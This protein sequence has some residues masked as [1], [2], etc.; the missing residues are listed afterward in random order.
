MEVTLTA[1]IP[2]D[3]I[4]VPATARLA[5]FTAE[6]RP[7]L[8]VN[9]EASFPIVWP[10][11]NLH[12]DVAGESFGVLFPTYARVQVLVYGGEVER[13]VAR[14]KTIPF[15]WDGTLEDPPTGIDAVGMRAL[16]DPARS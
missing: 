13:V 9:A 11:Y 10:E 3:G 6:E 12:G 14:G 15:R 7:D 4:D 2:R 16:E 8:W 1:M 5:V